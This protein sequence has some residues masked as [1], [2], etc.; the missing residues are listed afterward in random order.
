MV[1]ALTE[2]APPP[3]ECHELLGKYF[4]SHEQYR[5]PTEAIPP[6]PTYL[7]AM[8]CGSLWR[9]WGS[10]YEGHR[11]A[12]GGQIASVCGALQA[13]MGATES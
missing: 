10:V 1:R 6:A 7:A 13:Q 8:C 9:R 11:R 12:E 5:A 3:E 2:G 4:R